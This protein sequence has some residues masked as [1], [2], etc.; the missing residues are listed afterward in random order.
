MTP[1][2]EDDENEVAPNHEFLGSKDINNLFVKAK[3][4][5]NTLARS[6]LREKLWF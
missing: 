6:I 5:E 3:G 4:E 1:K 2:G